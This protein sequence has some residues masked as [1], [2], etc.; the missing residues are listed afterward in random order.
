LANIA[1]S[2]LDEH[3]DIKWESLGA[4]W[5]RA[6]RARTGT[7]LMRLIR[8]ADDFV[9]MIRGTRADAEALREEVQQV[10]S[11]M[12]LRLSEEKTKVTHI[13]EGFD[14]LGWHIQH[15]RK[16][17]QAGKT[18]VY[19]YPSAKSLASI[20]DK[21]RRL[22]RRS[23][24]RTLAD[25]LR[26]L[27]PALRGWCMY[28]QHGVVKHTFSCIDHFAFW[29]I[30]AWLKKRHPKLNMHTLVRRHLPGWEIRDG[31]IEFFRAWRIPVERY[32]YRG[33][34]IPTPWTTAA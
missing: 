33:S 14:F 3:F 11:R 26:R 16:R 28:F 6:K 7:P 9:V 19:T 29:R 12:G 23:L 18:A 31:G 15:R 24:H 21:V 8:Y 5:T 32:R 1:L 30:V 25:L 22:T 13:D 2:V 20:K 17:G 27:N 4:Y 34:R 10:L